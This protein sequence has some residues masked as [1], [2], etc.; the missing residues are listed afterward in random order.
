[1]SNLASIDLRTKHQAHPGRQ[2]CLSM[3]ECIC[4]GGTTIPPLGIFKGKNFLQNWFPNEVL[5]KWF[6]SANTKDWTSNLDGLKHVFEPATRRK[7]MVNTDFLFA[8]ATIHILL[9][10]L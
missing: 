5:E 6:Y 9:E 4:G 10:A 2:E 1:M 7:P 8:T 3:V